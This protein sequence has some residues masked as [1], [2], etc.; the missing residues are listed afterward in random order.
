MNILYNIYQHMFSDF[1]ENQG[2][3]KISYLNF[4][5][6]KVGPF[7]HSHHEWEGIGFMCKWFDIL[8]KSSSF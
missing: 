1:F 2:I 5:D 7:L 3:K 8:I 4:I 6:I